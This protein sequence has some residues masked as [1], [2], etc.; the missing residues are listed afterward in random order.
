MKTI[1]EENRTLIASIKQ[2]DSL[3]VAKLAVRLK[4]TTERLE[5]LTSQATA[6]FN[7]G[8]KHATFNK[9]T[10]HT[11]LEPL[12][13]IGNMGIRFDQTERGD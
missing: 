12:S 4:E 7:A 9:Q 10:I 3:L 6:Q 13:M 2:S 5:A 1:I 11:V 8:D